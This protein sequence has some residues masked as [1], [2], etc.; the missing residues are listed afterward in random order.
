MEK[1][2][3][4]SQTI[5]EAFLSIPREI[6]VPSFYQEQGHSYVRQT[7]EDLSEPEWLTAPSMPME[8]LVTK[9]SERHAPCSTSSQPTV[10]A[11]M[12]EALDCQPG[13]R[14]LEIGTGTGYN[15][16]LLATIT[17]NPADV[18]TIEVDAS[19]AAL[20]QERLRHTVGAV[21]VQVG[22]G[23][24]GAVG[25]T[26]FDRII[27]T[28]S[29]RAFPWEW[30]HQLAPG[31]RAILD[32]Q[33]NLGVSSF[34]TLVKSHQGNEANRSFQM[35]SLYFM[36]LQADDAPFVHASSAPTTLWDLHGEQILPSRLQ[37]DA[38]HWFLQWRR[39]LALAYVE[40]R[41]S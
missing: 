23:R 20:A 15:A 4:Y 12:L 31:G 24:K 37:E 11:R 41:E 29:C 1:G 16:A 21:Q 36:P 5:R 6:F 2:V 39:S 32:L 3:I 22:D 17:G 30:Y 27:A 8:S 34:C 13:M 10:M 25:N 18:T 7:S 40:V 28:A 9:L 14:V 33:G 19:T 35:P 26:T 38:F